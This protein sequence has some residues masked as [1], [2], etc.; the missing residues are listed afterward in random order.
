MSLTTAHQHNATVVAMQET[1]LLVLDKDHFREFLSMAEER[2]QDVEFH[3]VRCRDVLLTEPG[4]RSC[5]PVLGH[6]V[7]LLFAPSRFLQSA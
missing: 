4:S 3:P 1:I 5:T 7:V 6:I 2:H